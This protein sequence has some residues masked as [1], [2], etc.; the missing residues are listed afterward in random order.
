MD[1][2][3]VRSGSRDLAAGASA[4]DRSWLWLLPAVTPPSPQPQGSSTGSRAQP[5][6]RPWL[7]HG[8]VWWQAPWA[9]QAR[10]VHAWPAHKE[11]L[12]CLA[13]SEREDLLLTAGRGQAAGRG[14]QQVVRAWDLGSCEAQVGVWWR[15]GVAQGRLPWAGGARCCPT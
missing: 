12:R 15:G 2:L 8:H 1:D 3:L 10:V 4:G 5:A 14:A 7:H 9:L 13:A 6:P 11:R